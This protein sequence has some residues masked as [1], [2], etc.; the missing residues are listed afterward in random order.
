MQSSRET[1]QS[2]FSERDVINGHALFVGERLDLKILETTEVLATAPLVISAGESGCAV[3]FRYGVVILFGLQPLEEASFLI[4][5]EPLIIEPFATPE[6]E[7]IRL[8]LDPSGTERIDNDTLWLHGFSVER[9]Q[10]VA[11][12]LAKS[13]V[14]AHY[15]TGSAKIFD[16]IEPFAAKLQ[17]TIKD[18]RLS[19]EL[20][21]QIGRNLSIQNK[22]IGRVEIID[23]P[24]LLWD[25]PALERLYLRL[26]SEYEI[27]ERHTALERKLQLISQ[28]AE[29]ALD[30]LQ[31]NS[32]LRVEWYVVILIVAEILLS[33]YDIFVRTS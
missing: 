33:V 12:I 4:Q 2:L 9:I 6:T 11:D 22:I 14:L 23:K 5:L 28:T 20:L 24:E 13:V 16:Q 19:K 32:T 3:L 26:E 25:S 17:R 21:S 31:H 1:L 18:E 10:I 27:R 29:T 30:L 7:E 8:R 15:E